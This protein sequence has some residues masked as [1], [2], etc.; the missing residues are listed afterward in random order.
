[1]QP[2][3]NT[4]ILENNELRTED[5]S[6]AEKNANL[7]NVISEK[8]EE[9]EKLLEKVQYAEFVNHMIAETPY[10]I[11]AIRDYEAAFENLK[12]LLANGSFEQ[13]S[14]PA[15]HENLNF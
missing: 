4:L 13:V 7:K 8:T 1:M 5:G 3:L 15:L 11:L 9:E 10:S 14:F 2:L 12:I 6:F